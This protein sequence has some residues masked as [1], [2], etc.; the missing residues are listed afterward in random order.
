MSSSMTDQPMPET[1]STPPPGITG[2]GLSAGA[3][4]W[5]ILLPVVAVLATVPLLSGGYATVLLIEVMIFGI[6]ATGLNFLLGNMG[7]VSFCQGAFL[8]CGAYFTAVA[9]LFWGWPVWAAMAAAVAAAGLVAL[10]IGMFVMR[11]RSIQFL[12]ITLAFG[13]M[14]HTAAIKVRAT[15]GDDG[16]RGI[17]RLDLSALGLEARDDSVFFVVVLV[18]FAAA[19]IALK[20]LTV[21]R[22][23]RIVAGIRESETRMRS[24]GYETWGYRVAAFAVA[25]LFGGLAGALWAQYARFVNPELM[26]WQISGEALLMVIIGGTRNFFG[27]FLGALF[28]VLAKAWLATVT[29]AYLIVFGLLFVL[30]VAFLEGGISGLLGRFLRL[31]RRRAGRIGGEA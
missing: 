30:V 1:A 12:L 20:L 6:L 23:G 14:F 9:T 4:F 31:G 3:G 13:E 16:M 28:F 26:T 27:P 7:Y 25:G 2:T 11:T 18:V 17:P 5:A 10:L 21:S 24:L 8:G 19:M 15:G 29:D 22:F